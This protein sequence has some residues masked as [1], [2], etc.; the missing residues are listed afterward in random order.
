MLPPASILPLDGIRVIEIA[1]NLAGPHAGEILATLGADVIKVERPE[2]GDDA[3]GWGPPS[4]A[5][6]PSPS[7]P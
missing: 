4:P 3:R 7:M 6:L 1:Q 2:G 5:T